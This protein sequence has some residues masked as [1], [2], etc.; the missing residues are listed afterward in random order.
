MR[1]M[2]SFADLS[3]LSR[4]EWSSA[5][6]PPSENVTLTLDPYPGSIDGHVGGVIGMP[7][8]L[9]VALEFVVELL[10]TQFRRE[11]NAV[12]VSSSAVWQ[13]IGTFVGQPRGDGGVDVPFC[14]DVPASA[15]YTDSR[16]SSDRNH[17]SW[18]LRIASKLASE[19]FERHWRI[20]VLARGQRAS[21]AVARA[22]AVVTEADVDALLHLEQSSSGLT[23]DYP[24][25]RTAAAAPFLIV[26]G[27]TFCGAG[28]LIA[29]EHSVLFGIVCWIAGLLAAASGL[30]LVGNRLRVELRSGSLFITRRLFRIRVRSA[31]VALSRITGIACAK[32]GFSESGAEIK[33]YHRLMVKTLDGA[34][35][36]VGDSFVGY[37]E[38]MAGA[39]RLAQ[40]TG[41][42]VLEKE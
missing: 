9:S 29:H 11:G 17:N 39:R 26:G 16:S 32:T 36:V 2:P 35:Y 3:L 10:C 27:T 41:L 14:F 1:R 5:N 4:D 42:K 30:W 22:Q 38:A 21:A 13:D 19:D 28:W 6:M 25:G 33:V 7:S 20:P 12:G 8:G 24:P 23:M 37:G 34:S 40:L 18:T 31:A 15:P